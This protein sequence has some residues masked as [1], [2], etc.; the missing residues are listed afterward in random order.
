MRD[1]SASSS[2]SGAAVA[3]N[4]AVLGVGTDTSTSVRGPAAANGIVGLRPT[5]GVISR[6]GI[7]PKNLNTD[8]AGPMARTVR[9]LAILM[10]AI[11]GPDPN[12]PDGLSI[13]L[14]N[15]YPDRIGL[16]Y[17]QALRRGALQGA[18]IGVARDY[19]GGDPQADALAE[20]AVAKLRELGA[21][22]VDPVHLHPEVVEG[23][24]EIRTISDYRFLPDWE[25]YLATFGPEV[26]KT[27][28]EF[29]DIYENEVMHSALPVGPSVMSLLH[30]SLVT[31]PQDAP[32]IDLIENVYPRQTELK[33]E[34]FDMHQ[35]DALVF[36]YETFASPINNPVLTV[37]D[38]TFVRSTR[39]SPATIAGYSSIGFPGIVV[40]MGFDSNGLPGSLSFFG[41]P[42]D[43]FKLI[44][45]AFDYEQATNHRRPSPRIPPLPGETISY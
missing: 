8:T 41:R 5:T 44:G 21:V 23:Y 20:A 25:G 15:E 32:Y 28:Q 42:M 17:T 13:W 40:P 11:A 10:N 34:T 37:D 36:P 6:D 12:D 29:V 33:L 4:F 7:A 38:P 24:T 22:I 3:A 1:T 43:D 2:G 27:V 39:P 19:F 26:P 16:D 45:Y 18:R 14:F 35:L 30:R 9:D 31:S